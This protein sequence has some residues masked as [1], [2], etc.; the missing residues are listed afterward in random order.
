MDC[1]VVGCLGHL[2]ATT[3][4]LLTSDLTRRT[5]YC[6]PAWTVKVVSNVGGLSDDSLNIDRGG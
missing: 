3:G 6:L 1:C 5:I 2:P 4:Y